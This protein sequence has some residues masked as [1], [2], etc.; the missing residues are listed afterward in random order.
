MCFIN[1]RVKSKKNLGIIMVRWTICCF[2]NHLGVACIL[3]VS[4]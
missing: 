4:L 1:E 3:F 2:Y